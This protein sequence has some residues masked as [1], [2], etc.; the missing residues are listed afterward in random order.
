MTFSPTSRNINPLTDQVAERHDGSQLLL[1][2]CCPIVAAD[3]KGIL[4]AF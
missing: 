4:Q 3:I 2:V 1:V